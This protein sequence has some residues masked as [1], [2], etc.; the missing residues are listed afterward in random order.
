MAGR[1]TASALA[2]LGST[3][4]ACTSPYRKQSIKIDE[5][6]RSMIRG[7]AEWWERHAGNILILLAVL[8]LLV[9]IA[10][11]AAML[12]MQ[13]WRV[14][15]GSLADWVQALGTVAAFGALIFAG[16]E[17]K[18]NERDRTALERDRQI[19]EEERQTADR[20]RQALAEQREDERR[21]YEMSQARVVI[22]QPA[23]YEDVT[24]GGSDPPPAENR[25]VVIHN[26]SGSPIFNIHIRSNPGGGDIHVFQVYASGGDRPADREVL[27]PNESTA[28]LYVVGGAVGTP[29]TEHIEFTFTDAR[30]LRWLK[31]GSGQPVRLLE[32]S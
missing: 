29:S 27:P 10:V 20:E 28:K 5:A 18:S 25:E 17:W 31:R 9:V 15:L 2:K 7:V 30:G 8:A 6:R 32:S 3:Q 21:D 13:G 24:F 22:V 14:Q 4:T 26:H 23:P 12:Q 1:P 19:A 16:R 11:Q